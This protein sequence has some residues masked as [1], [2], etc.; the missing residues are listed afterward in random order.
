[1]YNSDKLCLSKFSHPYDEDPLFEGDYFKDIDNGV[2][3]ICDDSIP[4]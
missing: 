4:K 3:G 1:M 2:Y